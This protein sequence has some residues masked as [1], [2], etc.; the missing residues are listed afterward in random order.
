M[1]KMTLPLLISGALLI[2]SAFASQDN[3]AISY[4]TSWGIPAQAE[5]EMSRSKIDTLLLSFGQ[6]DAAG[7]IQISDGMAAIPTDT[8]WIP[9]AYLSWTQ[10]KLD[11][12]NRKIMVAFGGQTYESIWA[13]L[14]T[15]ESR[16]K[17]AQSLVTLLNQ[18]FP[19]F[20]RGEGE[21]QYKQV[22]SVQLDGIDFDFEKAA[23]V[24]PEENANL[25]ALANLVRQKAAAL[26]N[27]KLLSL[28]TYHVGA[29][30]LEC[31]N[32]A[33]T[34]DCSY[35]EPAR[36]S[37]HGE[38]L[39]ILK[40]GKEVFDFFNVMAYDAGP[41]FKYPVAMNNYARA[42]GNPAKIVL[43]ATINAQWGPEGNFVELRQNNIERAAW[44][45]RHNYGGFFVWT[46]GSNTE[47][48]HFTDQV[49]YLNDM[50]DAANE[51]TGHD[52]AEKPSSPAAL[53]GTVQ[54]DT[55]S[56]SWKA[57]TDNVG[58]TGYQIYRDGNNYGS[59]AKLQWTDPSAQ[60]GVEYRY[61]VKAVDAAGNRSDASN[62]IK[63][64]IEQS[65]QV[66]PN[67]PT[68]LG[69]ISA[70]KNSLSIKWAPV[71]N[72]EVK[73]YHVWRDGAAVKTVTDSKFQD[74]GLAADKSYVYRI[75]AESDKGIM[76]IASDPLQAKTL[77]DQIIPE[78]SEGE[79]EVGVN[80][81]VGE[82]VK[83]QGKKY[84]CLQAHPAM[85]HWNP[86]AAQSLWQVVP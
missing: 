6:W 2:P 45:A 55:I 70:T 47:S 1:K 50:K 62:E 23:R 7:N 27:K 21:S 42:V 41:R 53:K 31:A 80:Y 38:V 8:Y 12:P 19:V 61:S 26:P 52:D 75:I 16:E 74:T 9:S 63:V 58:V 34:Q 81:K 68:G 51:A 60:A 76:S 24:T 56:L 4:L 67:A 32:A 37:H 35:V 18:N 17:I 39:P 59:S 44:Q 11:N 57:S 29:D 78:P 40:G 66:K 86:E 64:K 83:Y 84:R 13:Y 25:L 49:T 65:G 33:V 22:G 5:K 71:T 77:P 10:F 28:T 79:W 73:R 3:R 30:P 54:N 14:S 69:L 20:K 82:L 15:P 43:G 85:A 46:L 72:V 36:S 48:M